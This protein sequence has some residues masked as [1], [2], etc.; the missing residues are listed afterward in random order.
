[1]ALPPAHRPPTRHP[2]ARTCRR[3]DRARHRLDP[4]PQRGRRTHRPGL[5]DPPR[6][7]PPVPSRTRRP[8]PARTIFNGKRLD[9]WLSVQ[10]ARNREGRLTPQ[11]IAA[12]DELGIH[13]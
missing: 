11:Q 8:P 3:A 12:L 5:A 9:A 1:M 7:R 10:R 13:W 4:R 6:R 2:P